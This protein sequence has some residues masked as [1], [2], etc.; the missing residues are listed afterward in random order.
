MICDNCGQRFDPIATRWR[1][2]HCGIKINC[3]EGAALPQDAASKVKVVDK[4]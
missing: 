3:C 2:I 1:C 4:I